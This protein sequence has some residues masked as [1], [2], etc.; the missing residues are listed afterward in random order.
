MGCQYNAYHSVAAIK[1][2]T[3]TSEVSI[4]YGLA[5]SVFYELILNWENVFRCLSSRYSQGKHWSNSGKTK[6]CDSMYL[7][8]M[9]GIS[10]ISLELL[11]VFHQ[12][13]SHNI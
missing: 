9:V 8:E 7:L 3:Q 4:Q 1:T 2:L 11:H 12:K 10:F 5:I 6:L 13:I